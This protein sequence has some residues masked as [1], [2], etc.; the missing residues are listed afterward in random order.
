MVD[1][2]EPGPKN[3]GLFKRLDDWADDKW[4]GEM[5]D[6]GRWA[7][8]RDVAVFQ[9][10]LALDAIRDLLMSPIS[11]VAALIGFLRD[12][13]RPGRY[14]YPL[15]RTGRQ[16][17]TIINLFGA[18]EHAGLKE[19]SEGTPTVDQWVSRLE[20]IVV[21]EYESGG[22]TAQAKEAIDRALDKAHATARREAE[23]LKT[24]AASKAADQKTARTASP[25]TDPR[26][27]PEA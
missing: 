26:D 19:R 14:F 15:M 7:L 6:P 8:M 18:A 12:K 23:S 22:V 10:K 9:G 16:T 4:G 2:Q 17:D 1:Q 27:A 25:A 3:A 11:I 20:D 21:K 13:D 5:E 24:K